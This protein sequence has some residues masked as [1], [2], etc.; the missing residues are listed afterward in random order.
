MQHTTRKIRAPDGVDLH[1]ELWRPEATPRLAV[2]VSHGSGDHVGRHEWLAE[3]LVPEGAAVFGPDH[4]G[5]GLSGGPRGHVDDFS[6]YARDLGLVARTIRGELPDGLPTILFGHSMG[7][8]I[9][10]VS[11]L[12]R[13]WDPPLAGAVLSAPL[14]GL[15]MPVPAVKRALGNLAAMLAPRIALPSGIPASG[16]CHDPEVIRA[17][18]ADTRRSTVVS[19]GWFAAMKRAI[20]RV[21]AE[22]GRV[23]LP[24][25]W[26]AGSTDPICDPVASRRAFDRLPDPAAHDQT[27]RSLEGYFHESHNEPGE[28]GEKVHDMVRGWIL[29]HARDATT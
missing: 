17:Y 9:A 2:V 10:L 6:T 1:V 26:Y 15:T 13:V 21:E 24:L 7:G 22:I 5:E 4:R 27:F 25:M 8:L 19:A 20:A 29:D 28:M 11:L 23:D 16:L 3:L 12:D 18:E 14:L